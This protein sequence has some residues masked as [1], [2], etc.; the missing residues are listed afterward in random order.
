MS[1]KAHTPENYHVV[2][3]DLVPDGEG[4]N[5]ILTRPTWPAA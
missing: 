2:T 5:L 1:G 3:F 4:T